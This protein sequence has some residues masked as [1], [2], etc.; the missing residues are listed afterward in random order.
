MTAGRKTTE[1]APQEKPAINHEQLSHDMA[2]A[3]QLGK[4]IQNY[5]QGR[6]LVNQLLG[7]AQAFQAA[8]DLLQTFGVSKLA[9]VKENKLYQ[10]LAGSTT[11]NGLELKGTWVEFC[12]LLGISD[13]KAN[14]DIANLQT[15]G[16]KALENMQRAG[17]GYRD[18]RQFRKLPTDQ[19][20]AL[21]E[22]AKEGDK[23]TLLELAEDL[24][25]KH[26][27]EKESFTKKLE[28]T[29]ASLAAS[30]VVVGEKEKTISNLQEQLATKK[31]EPT[32]TPEFAADAAL[33]DLDNEVASLVARIQAS[34]RSYLVKVI[35]PELE[36]GEILRQQ[37]IYG[38]VGRVLA[39]ARQ[40][41]QDFDVPV[42]GV[43]AADGQGEWDEIWKKSLQD[44]DAQQ[45]GLDGNNEE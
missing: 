39:A 35:E 41:A 17:I 21:I 1:I 45:A 18:L 16:E 44:F 27:R 2:A 37:A 25:A 9:I 10:Q 7:Q 4:A 13:E 6:D 5:G 40:V 20:T 23:G 31:P 33:R 8:G 42:T 15:F 12:N 14:Q 26:Q 32:P 36:I 28:D 29:E 38:A 11:P 43:D 19:R 22:A 3:A 34:L 24:I 30:R